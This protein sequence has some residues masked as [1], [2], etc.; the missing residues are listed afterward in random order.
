VYY[1]ILQNVKI[2]DIINSE[3]KESTRKENKKIKK[4]LDKLKKL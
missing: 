2:F 4:V 3:S 1:Y